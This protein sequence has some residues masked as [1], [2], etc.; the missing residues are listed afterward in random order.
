MFVKG[1]ATTSIDDVRAATGTSKSPLYQHFADKDALVREVI[2][3]QAA[4]LLA[5]Q[6]DQLKRLNSVRGLSLRPD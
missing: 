3:H 1:V 5:Q 6:E 2:E 4:E